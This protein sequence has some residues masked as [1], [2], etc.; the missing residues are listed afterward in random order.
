MIIRRTK[1]TETYDHSEAVKLIHRLYRRTLISAEDAESLQYTPDADGTQANLFDNDDAF[2]EKLLFF[3]IETTGLSADCSFLYL[4]GCLYIEC[5]ELILSQ[6]FSEG[7]NEEAQLITEFDKLLAEHPI[8]VHFNGSTFDI[9]YISKKRSRLGIPA[10][11]SNIGSFDIY[12]ILHPYKAFL[13]SGSMSQ[14]RLEEY[15]GLNRRDIYDG[16]ELIGFYN[17]YI[18]MKRLE[19]LQKRSGGKYI[20]GGMSGL[21]TAGSETSEE[22]LECLFLHNYEDVQNMPAISRLLSLP[23]F[24]QGGYETDGIISSDCRYI[25]IALTPIS[26]VLASAF[27]RKHYSTCN[28]SEEIKAIYE[29]GRC[30]ITVPVVSEELKLFYP[31]YKNYYY[32]PGEDYAIHKSIGEFMNKEFRT[33]CTADKCYTRHALKYLP[34]PGEISKKD[35]FPFKIFRRYY[36]DKYAYVSADEILN[37]STFTALFIRRLVENLF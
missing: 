30:I 21:T 20:P 7:I 28:P 34:L 9:P 13:G 24:L 31:D 32:L 35:E 11:D 3:D 26:P 22:L 29:G 12:K 14:K 5:G 4:I 37:N 10:P 1:I 19:S 17:R 6:F 27:T 16:G 18:A 2:A 8:L 36:N 33:K 25:Q 23:D 15:C